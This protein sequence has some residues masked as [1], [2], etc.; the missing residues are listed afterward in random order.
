MLAAGCRGD[1]P[2][3]A[4]PSNRGSATVSLVPRLP[5]TEDGNG[6]LRGV[7]ERIVVHAKEPRV[8]LALRLERAAI[9]GH[10]EDYQ[11]ALAISDE[12]IANAPD[13][14]DALQARIRA[15]LRVHHF[16]DARVALAKLKPKLEHPSEWRELEAQLDEATGAQDRS[17]PVRAQVAKEWPNPTSLTLYAASLAL[18]GKLDDALAT[19]PRAAAAIHDNSTELIAWLLF[20]WGRLYEQKGELAAARTF[21]AEAH[22]RL[23]RLVEATSHLAQAMIATGDRDGAK[24]I[25]DDAVALDQV[26]ELLA[27]AASLGRT[28]LAATAHD[29]W[30]RYVAALPEAFADHAARF[31]LGVGANPARALV[32]AKLNLA[33]RDT[34]EARALVVD[35]AL[36]AG[37]A[38]LAC[39][40]ADKVAVAA[41]LR[42]QR[43]LAWRAFTACKRKEDAARLGR[44]LGITGS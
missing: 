13:D 43:F 21:F 10:L 27:L 35:A 2:A 16:A 36:A 9:T 39:E 6:V 15:L 20:Q 31:Y 37:D 29:E 32:L 24:K 5:R 17:A 11:R 38:K 4:P 44:E 26:P 30:E 34:R 3:A 7:D 25:V 41:A 42:S 33:N 18:D 8:E 1:A 22:A 28:S 23:P 40:S 12:L 14:P 19:M